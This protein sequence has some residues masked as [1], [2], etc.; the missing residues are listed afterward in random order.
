MTEEK[1]CSSCT[2]NNCDAKARR[3]DEPDDVFLERQAI[4]SRLCRIGKKLVVL[5]GKGGVGKSTA[6]VNLAAALAMA[7]KRVGLMDIDIHGPSIPKLLHLEKTQ[8]QGNENALFPVEVSE[9]LVVMSIGLLLSGQDDAVI[10]RG[11]RKYNLIKQFLKDVEWGDLDFLLVDCPP[12]TGDEPLSI[13]QLLEKTDGA[14]VITTPQQLAVQDVRRSIMFCRQLDIPVFGVIENM[15]GFVCP[16][17][18]KRIDI[19]GTGGG[20]AMAGDLGVPFLGAIPIE[21][22]VVVSGDK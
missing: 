19:F 22:Q 1:T 3:P 16:E 10:W 4:T 18:N 13:V 21:T 8:V 9:N 7:G 2:E 14:I 12:G 11:P 17:C 20:E 5:S 15:S 6:A